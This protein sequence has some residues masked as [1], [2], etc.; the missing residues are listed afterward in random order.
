MRKE[1]IEAKR[2]IIKVGTSTLIYPN[3]N[4]NLGA[5]DQLAFVLSDLRNQGKEIVL[6][7][8]GAVGVGMHK[9]NLTKRP[10]TIPAQQAIAAIGQAE[11]M[12]IYNQRFSVYGQQT[13]QILVTRDVIDYPESRKNV[14]N[15]LEQL[16]AMGTIPI[17]NENDTVA[18]DELDHPTKFGDNDQLSAI[19]TKLIVAD[20]L[21]ILSDIDGFY[22]DNPTINPDAEMYQT[23]TAID[24]EL[25]AQAGGA[26]S[27]YGTGG[28]ASK[29]K[30][31]LRI[32]EA[33][34][35]MILANGKNPAIIFDILAGKEIGTLFKEVL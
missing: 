21:I 22:S 32:F 16:L 2:I 28:M 1:I 35:P 34:R 18:V 31:A 27:A 14:V 33:N 11:L 7:S 10:T 30:A 29:L 20:L 13:A 19:V 15:T 8:S 24:D 17:V 5:I 3:G 26:G 4:I 23:V 9:M 25:M 6:V 12:N